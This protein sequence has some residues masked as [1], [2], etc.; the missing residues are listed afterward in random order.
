MSPPTAQ[1]TVTSLNNEPWSRRF[2]LSVPPRPKLLFSKQRVKK[3]RQFFIC[4]ITDPLSKA[5]E[6]IRACCSLLLMKNE[7]W[8]QPALHLKFRLQEYVDGF[9]P[10]DCLT[11]AFSFRYLVHSCSG[12]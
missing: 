1:G 3:H 10:V 6:I 4:P 9:M 5:T 12:W 11:S 8:G 2:V 7:V